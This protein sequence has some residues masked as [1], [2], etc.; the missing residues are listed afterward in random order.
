MAVAEKKLQLNALWKGVRMPKGSPSSWRL[1]VEARELLAQLAQAL[2]ISQTSVLELAIRR[3][4]KV[5][6]PAKPKAT[7]RK[8]KS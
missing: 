2:G 4:A 8:K 5:E 7:G 1:S 6:L 3:M